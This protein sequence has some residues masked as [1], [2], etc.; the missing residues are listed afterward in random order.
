MKT[1]WSGWIWSR[2]STIL[3]LPLQ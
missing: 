2:R 3:S 1:S